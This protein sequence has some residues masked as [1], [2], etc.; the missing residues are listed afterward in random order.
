MG[1]LAGIGYGPLS[2]SSAYSNRRRDFGVVFPCTTVYGMPI[3]EPSHSPLPKSAC[4]PESPIEA[5][6]VAES[7]A[8]GSLST[9]SF[10]A[11]VAGN[12]WQPA[13]FGGA[14]V[15]PAAATQSRAAPAASSFL[16]VAE[17][18]APT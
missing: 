10:H 1:T 11:F 2:L 12:T 9:R 5:I 3:L 8:T 13:S 7:A 14:G 4:T 16:T 15:A 18:V 17:V 6:S